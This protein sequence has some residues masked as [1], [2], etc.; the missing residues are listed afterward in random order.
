MPLEAVLEVAVDD[1]ERSLV[2]AIALEEPAAP[3]TDEGA[4]QLVNALL[5]E[6]VD[7]QLAEVVG[8][9]AR[10]NP[11]TDPERFRELN[12]R[13]FALEQRRRE[14]RIVDRVAPPEA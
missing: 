6:R 1:E 13:S 8:E 11:T 3:D 5:A 4:R 7:A 9:L 14:L 2:R 12:R 10:V